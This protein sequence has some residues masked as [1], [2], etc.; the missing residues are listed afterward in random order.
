MKTQNLFIQLGVKKVDKIESL[1][2]DKNDMAE[3]RKPLSQLI[4]ETRISLNISQ[5]S[6]AKKLDIT[7]AQLSRLESGTAKKPNRRTLQALLPYLE[8]I[9]Y[10]DLLAMAGY[11]VDFTDESTVNEE[12]TLEEEDHVDKLAEE[13]ENI[14]PELYDASKGLYKCLDDPKSLVLLQKIFY[15]VKQIGESQNDIDNEMTRK[16]YLRDCILNLLQ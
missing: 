12:F 14:K 3:N 11:S 4:R 13:F 9:P 8:G 1:P 15:L 16:R 5:R 2:K 10:E 7:Q 6:F